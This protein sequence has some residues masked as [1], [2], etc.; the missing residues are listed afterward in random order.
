MTEPAVQ[1]VALS[2]SY[3]KRHALTEASFALEPGVTA[4]LGQNG[5]G[6]STLIRL[7]AT[8]EQ[9][10]SGSL[11]AGHGS[12][13]RGKGV[14]RYRR[15][16]G[17]LPQSFSAPM[18]SSVRQFVDYVAWLKEVPRADRRTAVEHAVTSVGLLERIDDRLASLS[19][20]MLRRIGLA[21][22]VVNDPTVLL[23]DE[24][25][26]GLDPRQRVEFAALVRSHS[27]GTVLLA[28]HLLED[29]VLAAE[30]LIVLDAGTV[31]FAG[32]LADFC[33]VDRA[34]VTV[35]VLSTRFS[36]ALPAAL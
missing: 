16:L 26:A 2:K 8:V 34:D 10:D 22:A 3:G 31:L 29:V 19:G 4:L 1:A 15:T 17:W 6:K 27:S 33:E 9:P 12:L 28:T 35:E 30:S 32:S 24:P 11:T 21:Q 36:A 14:R 7:L 23:L 18:Q 20:G 5:A 13:H 25:T